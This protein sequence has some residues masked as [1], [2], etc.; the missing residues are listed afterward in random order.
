YPLACEWLRGDD[1]S[2][3]SLKTLGIKKSIDTEESA[4][5]NLANFSRIA[6]ET[7]PIVLCFDQLNN[8]ARLPDGSRALQK[9]FDINTK[10]HDEDKNFL[11]IIS[12]NTDVWKTHFKSMDKSDKDR[13][14]QEVPL[15]SINLQQAES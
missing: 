9:M 13:I 10:I 8:I 7:Q 14:D 1:L 4:R 12:L 2:E 6:G 3:D 5:G 11:I 15:K